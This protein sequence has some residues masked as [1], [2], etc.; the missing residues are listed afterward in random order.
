VMGWFSI[1]PPPPQI[2][3]WLRGDGYLQPS[4]SGR[5]DT[6]AVDQE[7]YVSWFHGISIGR[8]TNVETVVGGRALGALHRNELR[9]VQEERDMLK[10]ER[11]RYQRMFEE[12]QRSRGSDFGG[13]STSHA[14]S[15]SQQV[16]LF[17]VYCFV[18]LSC[19]FCILSE[20]VFPLQGPPYDFFGGA[21]SDVDPPSDDGGDEN[22]PC[23]NFSDF[24]RFG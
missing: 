24:L 6:P 4:A 20:H 23:F 9:R 2:T 8:F 16:Y 21:P 15:S 11:D 22:E 19:L 12:L 17:L 3:A 10:A 13:G 18:V 14:G 7:V 1:P 5:A